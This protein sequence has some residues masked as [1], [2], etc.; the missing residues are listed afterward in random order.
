M[1]NSL[2]RNSHVASLKNPQ[3]DSNLAQY[4]TRIAFLIAGFAGA[5]WAPIIPYV[6]LRCGLDDAH[7]G[8]LLLCLGAGSIVSM[9]VAGSLAGRYGCRWII[10]IAT[11]AICAALPVLASSASILLV[12]IALIVFGA[13]VGT[14]DCVVNVQAVIVERACRRTMMS[15]FHGLFSVGGLLGAVGVSSLLSLGLSPAIASV[16]VASLLVLSGIFA[17]PG[18]LTGPANSEESAVFVLPHGVVLAIGIMCFIVFLTEGSAIDW[19]AVFLATARR[20]DMRYTGLGYVAFACTMTVGRLLGDYLVNRVSGHLLV[21]GGSLLA[22]FGMLLIAVVPVWQITLLGYALVGGGC[23]NV[24]PILYSAVGRQRYMPEHLAVSAI[25]TLGYAGILAGPAALGFIAQITDL[26][27]SL[28][29]VGGLLAIV[30]I[31]G[32]LI[33]RTLLQ[34]R[35]A[36]FSV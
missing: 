18:L 34:N 10:A 33:P 8:L 36:A 17:L 28:A 30:S 2:Q 24:V 11:L 13:G 6:K 19:S 14:I 31:M 27:F 22:A 4:S 5:A 20:V 32:M 26:S 7:L 3:A 16:S 35:S 12:A 23:S 21:T 29:I 25:T 1:Q 15:G 9:P